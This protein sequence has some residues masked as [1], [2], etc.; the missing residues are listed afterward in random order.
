MHRQK[1]WNDRSLQ[2]NRRSKVS[3]DGFSTIEESGGIVDEAE[4]GEEVKAL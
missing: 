4:L 2:L 1:L 3:S